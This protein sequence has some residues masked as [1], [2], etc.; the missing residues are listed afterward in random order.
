MIRITDMFATP[1]VEARFPNH[2]P[3]CAA[4]AKLFLEK[5][6]EGERYRDPQKRLTQ[7]GPLFESRFDLFKWTDPPVVLVPIHV[8]PL[9]LDGELH[10]DRLNGR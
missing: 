8:P 2:A 1:L 10:Q 6:R 7:F 4:L 3:L 5:E 9:D